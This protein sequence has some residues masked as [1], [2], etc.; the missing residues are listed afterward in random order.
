V[1]R[2]LLTQLIA[3]ATTTPE[4]PAERLTRVCGN[5][6]ASFCRHVLNVTDSE[7]LASASPLILH[8]LHVILIV[9]VAVVLRIIAGRLIRRI[10]RTTAD[11][12][13][14]RQLSRLGDA[15]RL[16]VS[17]EAQARRSAR[18]RTLGSVLG[19]LANAI[20][21]T[22]AAVLVLGELGIDL[23]PIIA[24]AGIAGVALGFGA[25]S[26][27][28]DFLSG[29]F[30]VL[31]DQYGVGDVVTVGTV[32]GTVESVGLRSTRIRDVRGTLWH[33]RNGEFT[34]AGNIS[35]GWARIVLDV[36]LDHDTDIARA[37]E[38]I[39]ATAQEVVAEPRF[40]NLVEDAPSVWGVEEVTM[41]G[42][43]LRLAV[44]TTPG[45]KDD[46][47]RAL[48][49]RMLADFEGSGVALAV[50]GDLRRMEQ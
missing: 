13:V 39:L 44:K 18:A 25:Q 12:R 23:A 48:R 5:P 34:T 37:R 35:Q 14:N 36:V 21:G 41:E 1:V 42:V 33:Q 15:V 38:V 28:K 6:P 3:A 29:I 2:V 24:S 46:L 47:A 30:I 45:A 27:V 16:D 43:T 31:E 7:S 26:I 19:S 8:S 22:V 11:G 10:A 4:T 50:R 17:A 32:T 20:I 49:E 40:V 9:L